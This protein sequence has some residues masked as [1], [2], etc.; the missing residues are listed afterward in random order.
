MSAVEAALL[1]IDEVFV[2]RI[3]PQR[4]AAGQHCE[5][6]DLVRDAA[7]YAAAAAS[8][9]SAQAKPMWQG[10]VRVMARGATVFFRFV[11]PIGLVRVARKEA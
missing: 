5:E 4:S 6:W 7:A 2:Y 3:P 8:H 11:A 9:A 10:A 1:Q